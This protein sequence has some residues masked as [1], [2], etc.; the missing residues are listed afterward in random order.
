M[1]DC[2]S[3]S[4]KSIFESCIYT[5]RN[6]AEL[7]YIYNSN[8]A[9]TFQEN[10]PWVSG[11]EIL[12]KAKSKG[13]NLLLFFSAA[14]FQSGLIYLAVLTKIEI[15]KN[16]TIYSFKDLTKIECPKK[17]SELVLLSTNKKLSNNYIR[18][19][20]L[21]KTPPNITDWIAQK[22][23]PPITKSKKSGK[24][25]FL[26]KDDQLNFN[27]KSF[28]QWANSD[29]VSNTS[30]GILA[31]YIVA[32]ALNL[33]DKI[34]NEWDAFDLLLP[35]GIKL[36][37]KS[38]SYIQSWQQ[39]KYSPIIFNIPRTKAW[40]EQTNKLEN[41]KKRQAD[42]YIFCLL[43]HKIQD[44]LNPLNLDQWEFYILST[45]VLNR[46]AGNAKTISLS[47]LKKLNAIQVDYFHLKDEIYQIS[48]DLKI[49]REQ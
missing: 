18:P 42:I 29:L 32:N 10:K 16:G 28:W 27:L 43:K 38:A 33:T 37:V 44:S 11:Y 39:K 3:D 47:K 1:K 21:C 13:E 25:L 22:G 35:N 26:Y 48:D 6:S 24:E 46:I 17:L 30:R 41:E 5:M 20:A 31:E 36:E 23:L 14:D 34:R 2:K 9:S 40:D 45:K 8:R 15:V 19:Y 7:D 49:D 4:F 12:E